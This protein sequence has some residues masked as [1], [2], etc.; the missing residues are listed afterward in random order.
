MSARDWASSERGAT[1][2][3]FVGLL[4]YLLFALLAVWQ[5]LLVGAA[6]TA[7][8]H[9]ARNASR[10]ESIGK[11]PDVVAVEAL[12]QWLRPGAEV[13]DHDRSTRVTVRVQV[14]ILVPAWRS[15]RFAVARDAELPRTAAVA[16]ERTGASW[17]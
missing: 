8:E 16:P 9:A 6:A 1:A 5:L 7:A 2:I 17:A 12:P 13:V 10:G 3:E 15:T 4:P 11:R 14:P